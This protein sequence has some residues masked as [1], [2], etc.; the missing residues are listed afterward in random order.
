MSIHV[1]KLSYALGAAVTNVDLSQELDAGTVAAIRQAWL[2]HL[3]LV[4][5][6]Q[7]ISPAEQIRFSRYLGPV[8]EYPLE[9]YRLPG[10]P[11]IFYLTNVGDDGRIGGAQMANL[12]RHWH[13]DLSF[14]AHP[15]MGSMLRCM[16]IPDYGGTTCFA[17]QYMAYERLSPTFQ[18]LIDPLEA[19]HELFSKTPN[20]KDL[21]QGQIKDMRKGNPRIA[22]PVVRTHPET[23]RKALFVSEALCSDIVGMNRAESSALLEFLFEHQ[24][25]VEYTYRHTWKPH[26]IVL[27]DNR[28][29]LHMAVPD[30]DHLQPR[31][32]YRTTVSG[33]PCGT[34]VDS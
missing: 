2:D 19:V 7:N 32:M 1:T 29:T 12:G 16:Q 28:C 10:H 25:R 27:W 15:A 23:G 3:V 33:T 8:E 34:L 26:D 18:A 9:P 30:N 11:E 20:L 14:T 24:T 22:Q 31:V 17:N 6:G 5:P 21:D 4:F 13:S